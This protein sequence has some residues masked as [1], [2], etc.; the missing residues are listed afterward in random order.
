METE[1]LFSLVYFQFF[2]NPFLR[3]EKFDDVKAASQWCN[4]KNLIWKKHCFLDGLI[5]PRSVLRSVVNSLSCECTHVFLDLRTR[6]DDGS[7]ANQ[8]T[9]DLICLFVFTHKLKNKIRIRLHFSMMKVN[10]KAA[11]LFLNEF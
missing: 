1:S 9:L 10:R 4:I 7:D 6:M 11:L 3:E 5:L 8:F 2:A